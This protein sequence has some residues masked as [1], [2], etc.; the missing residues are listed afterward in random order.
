MTHHT[1]CWQPLKS[2]H[3]VHL[4][5]LGTSAGPVADEVERRLTAV[6][7]TVL[8]DDRDERPGVKLADA[9]LI[10]IPL[11]VVVGGR[12]LGA[13]GVEARER[14]VASEA[15]VV[16]IEDVAEVIRARSSA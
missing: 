16:A 12:S 5:S 6:G 7:V 9:D 15:V 13:G 1:P 2:P 4:V 10:G 8:Y 3:D 14:G 11:Q